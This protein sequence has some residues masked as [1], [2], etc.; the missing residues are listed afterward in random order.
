M[1]ILD[2]SGPAV[3][4]ICRSGELSAPVKGEPLYSPCRC[5]GTMGLFHASCLTKWLVTS[6]TRSCEICRT[7]FYINTFY[8]SFWEY[9]RNEARKN[10]QVDLL[11]FLFLTPLTG[12]SAFLCIYSGVRSNLFYNTTD[13]S[14][15]PF[16][17]A[18]LFLSF[19]L[20]TMY[21]SWLGV[22]VTHH[23][24]VFRHYKENNPKYQVNLSDSD[25]STGTV[26]L[27]EQHEMVRIE[28]EIV[29]EGVVESIELNSTDDTVRIPDSFT[30]ESVV[31]SFTATSTPRHVK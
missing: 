12:V 1:S 11:C 9:I 14:S 10:I 30:S 17:I 16:A 31:R 22:T 15:A 26:T 29:G 25:I 24:T 6:R 23:L 28:H 21:L 19:L 3:C 20:I 13:G 27:K 2:T 18:L 4:R 7:F 5:K 8:P